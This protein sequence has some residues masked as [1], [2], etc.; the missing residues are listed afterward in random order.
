MQQEIII[1]DDASLE[2]EPADAAFQETEF[3]DSIAKS[4][5][6]VNDLLDELLGD[7]CGGLDGDDSISLLQK[8]LQIKPIELEKLCLPELQYVRR[9]DLKASEAKLPKP[10]H[11][12]SDV[13]NLLKGVSSKTPKK[14][15]QAES[16][17]PFL[18]SPT[19]AKSPVSSIVSLKKLIL[20]SNPLSGP[21]SAHDINQSTAGSLPASEI[22]KK[23]ADQVNMEKE[24]STS[25]ELKSS[26]IKES[27]FV[28]TNLGLPHGTTASAI[29]SAD[30]TVNDYLSRLGSG[31]DI[32]SGRSHAYVENTNNSSCMENIREILDRPDVV[33]DLQTTSPSELDDKEA[34]DVLHPDLNVQNSTIEN[35]NITQN[36]ETPAVVEDHAA[37]GPSN[38]VDTDQEQHKEKAQIATE[39][40]LNDRSKVKSH[41]PQKTE[42]KKVSHRQNLAGQLDQFVVEEHATDGSS[43]TAETGP[44][45]H[46]KG[47]LFPGEPLNEQSK[48]ISRPCKKSRHEEISRRQ[49]LAASGT[50]WETGT[51]RSTRIKSRPLEYWKG[52]RFLYGRVHQSLTTVIGIKYVSP[53]SNDCKPTMKVKSYVSDQYKDL[54]DLAAR[55]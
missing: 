4:E 52:E 50:S 41:P 35:L 22:I 44:E 9:I 49:S 18:A 48:V 27:D 1:P 38:I 33:T 53:G 36:Q 20:Q 40:P 21:Y 24:L 42:R 34:R 8:H 37:D 3:P 17:V 51:R 45:Q 25:T 23:Q 46:N 55:F 2:R 10:R 13:Q 5:K 32:G 29:H 31:M 54:V 26:M 16:P 28:A 39:E 30:K 12:L 11:V 47:I 43:N 7:N 15:K 14:C 6:K 19:P